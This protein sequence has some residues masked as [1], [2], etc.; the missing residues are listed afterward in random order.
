MGVDI[1][2]FRLFKVQ[3]CRKNRDL[4]T[5]APSRGYQR[6]E[7]SEGWIFRPAARYL[8]SSSFLLEIFPRTPPRTF[9]RIVEFSANNGPLDCGYLK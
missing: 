4:E 1:S 7:D 2:D 8:G 3:P 9:R 6:N 5:W